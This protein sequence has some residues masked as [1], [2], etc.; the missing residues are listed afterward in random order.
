MASI[1][2]DNE[3]AFEPFPAD[4]A[5]VER[6]LARLEPRPKL[7]YI[8]QPSTGN[9]LWVTELIRLTN[10]QTQV[11]EDYGLHRTVL[12]PEITVTAIVTDGI[13]RYVPPPPANPTPAPL[14]PTGFGPRKPGYHMSPF[15]WVPDASGGN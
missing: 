9:F 15:G 3:Y 2:Y 8:A 10:P 7:E 14:A 13:A 1:H 5:A 11:S 12:Y 4:A 6:I